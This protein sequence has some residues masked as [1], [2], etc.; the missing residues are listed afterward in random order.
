M[1]GPLNSHRPV[2]LEETMEALYVEKGGKFLDCTFGGGGH[3]SAILDGSSENFVYAI[4]R[5]PQAREHARVL[6]QKYAGRFT[7]CNVNFADVESMCFPALNGILM[8]LGMSSFQLDDGVRGFSFKEHAK[9]DMRM[10]NS[11]GQ[12]ATEFLN[13]ASESELVQAIREF[14]EERNWKK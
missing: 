3:T 5:D 14:G 1:N 7:F 13:S 9:L 12:T 6:Q 11:Y 10:D 8:D 2:L 4:D